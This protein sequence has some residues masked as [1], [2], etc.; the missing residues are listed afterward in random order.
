[1]GTS[2]WFLKEL[3]DN[4]T[5]LNIFHTETIWNLIHNNADTF[6]D[7]ILFWVFLIRAHSDLAV[8]RQLTNPI[9]WDFVYSIL[10][11]VH[12]PEFGVEW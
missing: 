6:H 8:Q 7:F 5:H 3:E 10:T 2:Y 9:V 4:K 12:I 1:M 11:R